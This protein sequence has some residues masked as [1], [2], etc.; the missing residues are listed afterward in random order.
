MNT[1]SEPDTLAR[2]E[3][4]ELLRSVPIGRIVFTKHALPAITPVNFAVM[5]NGDVI[6]RTGSGS[7][8]SAAMRGA[9]VAFEADSF[10]ADSLGGWSVVV[11]GPARH[12]VSPEEIEE[13]DGGM[14]QPW[15]SGERRDVIRI[16]A[17]FV[18]GRRL[19]QHAVGDGTLVPASRDQRL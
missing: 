1:A 11:T 7:K 17:E 19:T 9:V 6:I 10:D 8:L 14:P 4:L 16:S 18:D 13:I 2:D 12:V 5:P 3:S 15:V